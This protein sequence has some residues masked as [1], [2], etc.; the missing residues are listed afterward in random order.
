[1]SPEFTLLVYLLVTVFLLLILRRL[2]YWAWSALLL[3][4]VVGF[5]VLLTLCPPGEINPWEESE[6]I[7]AMYILIITLTPILVVCYAIYAALRN[8]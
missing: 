4:S 6:S 5:V 2:G 1:M 8:A 3:A 7:S